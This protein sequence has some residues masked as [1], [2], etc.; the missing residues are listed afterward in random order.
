MSNNKTKLPHNL[1]LSDLL[2][3]DGFKKAWAAQDKKA[4][5]EILYD[6]GM[7]VS[8]GYEA[9]VCEHRNLRNQHVVCHYIFGYMRTDKKWTKHLTGFDLAMVEEDAAMRTILLTAS[10]QGFG[11]LAYDEITER[12]EEKEKQQGNNKK[13]RGN[14]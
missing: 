3:V 5:D 8:L 7:D 14:K 6:N 4:I 2:L 10:K 9:K 12:S 11:G 1:S 13:K